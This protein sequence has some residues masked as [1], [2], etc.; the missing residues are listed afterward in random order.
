MFYVSLIFSLLR[1][2]LSASSFNFQSFLRMPF[3]IFSKNFNFIIFFFGLYS[4]I[5]FGQSLSKPVLIPQRKKRSH[6]WNFFSF[7]IGKR[8]KREGKTRGALYFKMRVER[9]Y[10][11]VQNPTA[12]YQIMP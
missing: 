8:N 6:F 11:K 5:N 12:K 9:E 4:K 1:N 7:A 10:R 3:F 2:L